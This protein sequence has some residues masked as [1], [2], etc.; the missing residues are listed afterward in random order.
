MFNYYA[1][2]QNYTFKT[3]ANGY[4][5]IGYKCILEYDSLDPNQFL[6]HREKPLFLA[7]EQTVFS[8]GDV[9]EI[10]GGSYAFHYKAIINGKEKE[11]GNYQNLNWGESVKSHLELKKY[12]KF[13]VEYWKENP[14]RSILYLDRPV[15]DTTSIALNKNK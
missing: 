1:N 3:I 12:A 5:V 8:V 11:I 10:G 6:L 14:R 4:M 7:G 2:G 13:V 9:S 15:K